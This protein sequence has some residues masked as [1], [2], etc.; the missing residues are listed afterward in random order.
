[1]KF[2]S[3]ICTTIDESKHLLLIGLKQETADCYHINLK[4]PETSE[5]CWIAC[6]AQIDINISNSY[7]S[8]PAWS[9]HRLFEI[10][11]EEICEYLSYDKPYER[12]IQYIDWLI[13]NEYMNKKYLNKK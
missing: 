12:V 11:G 1:M 6:E 10:A 13:E 3:Q 4:N 5:D 9:L 8:I 2:S 7:E